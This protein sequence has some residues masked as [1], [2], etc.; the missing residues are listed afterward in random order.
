[1]VDL[2]YITTQNSHGSNNKRINNKINKK[3]EI[4]S[5]KAVQNFKLLCSF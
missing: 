1:M 4:V 3:D 2:N 5:S